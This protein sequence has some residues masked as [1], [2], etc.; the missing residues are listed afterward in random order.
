MC[1]CVCR[2][3][4]PVLC[5]TILGT[6]ST[7][8]A[9]RIRGE[10]GRSNGFRRR[11]VHESEDISCTFTLERSIDSQIQVSDWE[12]KNINYFSFFL[13]STRALLF[14]SFNWEKSESYTSSE[15]RQNSPKR[16]ECTFSVCVCACVCVCASSLTALFIHLFEERSL[17]YDF[18]FHL[19]S[20]SSSNVRV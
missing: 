15:A 12:L 6:N 13:Y 9:K 7:W 19:T 3:L 14:F 16:R 18:S 10:R 5:S 1:E 8:W 20:L 17:P 4:S 2:L 11:L